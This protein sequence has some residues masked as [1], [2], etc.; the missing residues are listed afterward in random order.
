MICPGSP[1]MHVTRPRGGFRVSG[2]CRSFSSATRKSLAPQSCMTAA[3]RRSVNELSSASPAERVDEGHSSASSDP[4]A[5]RSRR[6]SMSCVRCACSQVRRRTL[7]GA[8]LPYG[9]VTSVPPSEAPM[10]RSMTQTFETSDASTP[11]A[12]IDILQVYV[13][14]ALILLGVLLTGVTVEN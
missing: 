7:T 10:W 13:G 12:L 9:H 1:E 8:P 3:S 6:A 4:Q 11:E 5:H 14:V 2:L